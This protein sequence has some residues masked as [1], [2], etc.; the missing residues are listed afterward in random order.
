MSRSGLLRHFVPAA[1][2]ACGALSFS[3]A[4]CVEAEGRF[5]VDRT[6]IKNE[7][8]TL[9]C[10]EFYTSSVN[11]GYA[12]CSD[13]SIACPD[14]DPLLACEVVEVEGEFTTV[15]HEGLYVGVLLINA[16]DPSLENSGNFNDVETSRI[17]V[18]GYD[19]RL[20]TGISEKT[21]IYNSSASIAPGNGETSIFVQVVPL[22]DDG[23]EVLQEA[24]EA[25]VTSGFAGV[26]FYGR[27]SGGID[28]ETPEFFL[29]VTF[30]AV[31][32]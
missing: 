6:C 23:Q 13:L 1:L 28:V 3:A 25:G 19:V 20:D 26:R 4:G 18:S 2:V 12:R 11:V 10:E 9:E 17:F 5:Y 14:S 21:F 24:A 22:G 31:T 7:D 32:F 15:C 8:G 30:S 16:M 29:P 27:T